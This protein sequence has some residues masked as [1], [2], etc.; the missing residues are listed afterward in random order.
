MSTAIE[1]VSDLAKCH[2]APLMKR[3]RASGLQIY[4]VGAV[5]L[6]IV[7]LITYQL[8]GCASCY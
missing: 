4:L 5:I 6:G 1:N 2:P 3:S 8:F 7:A